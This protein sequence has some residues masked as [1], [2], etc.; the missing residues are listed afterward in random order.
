L[1]ETIAIVIGSIFVLLGIAGCVLPILPGPV[2]IFLGL[3]LPALGKDFSP[4]LTPTLMIVMALL[5]VVVT[6]GDYMIPLWG[7]KKY[8]TSKWG[9]WGSVAGMVVG[10]FFSPFGMLVGALVGAV[11]VEWLVQKKKE[12]AF[13]AGWGI[14]VG[15]LLGAVLK[16]GVSGMMVY[17][18]IRGLW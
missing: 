13:R 2:L 11:A 12:K 4:P 15:S 10:L 8:G 3:L 9:I 17:Y 14:I 7:A 16:L 18:F 1:P 6:I 5:T